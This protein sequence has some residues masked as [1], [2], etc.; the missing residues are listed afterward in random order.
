MN[1]L[2]I[3]AATLCLGSNIFIAGCERKVKAQDK[4]E[5]STGPQPTTVEAD[6]DANNF[7]VDHPERFPLAT[8]GEHIAAP[9][10]NVTGVVN[11]DV[12]R[13]VPVPS[14][15]TGRITEI[16]ARLGDEV[17][18]GQLL[19][20][21]RSADIANA[22]SNYRQAVKNEQLA[23]D[24]E[25]LSKIQLNR[26]TLLFDNGAIPRSG[27]E[28]AQNAEV[29]TQTALEDARIV[30]ETAK[31]QLG[32]LGADPDH[33]TGIVQVFAPVSGTITD[34]EI[35][36]Q[37]AVQSYTAPNPFTISDLSH[38]WIVCDVWENNM[39][40]V[41]IGE[42]ADIHL[43]AYPDRVLKGRISNI[44]PI[45]DPNIRT[46]KVRLQVDNP[47]L[48]RIGM[49][50][51]ATFHGETMEKRATVPASAIL[52]LHDRQWVY[53]PLGNGRF[54]REEVTAANML[55]NNM[56]EVVRGI[57]PGDRVITNALVFQNTVEQ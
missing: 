30:T 2:Y 32:L 49:F 25:R 37:S 33:P 8:A 44:L 21:V 34:Q 29:G 22:F 9:E 45:I 40:Q 41:H 42:Y 43:V 23:V 3:I 54:R 51:T 28:I 19:F 36:D 39:A 31:E 4:V 5:A 52:H 56:Q 38:V 57:K 24:N 55:P 46:A 48:M 47:G 27:L 53:L 1:R 10:L 50:V 7:K 17:Q 26:A 12:S 16:D 20:K 18:K 11:P 14:L 15:A 6:L 13:Q 35:T